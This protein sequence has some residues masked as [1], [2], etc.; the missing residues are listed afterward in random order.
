MFGWSAE[1]VV[2]R[3]LANVPADRQDEFRELRGRVL[4][5]NAFAEFETRRVRKDGRELDVLISTAPLH[6]RTGAI[7]GL[8]ALYQDV[9]A[10][11]LLE[12]DLRQA[13]KMEAVG[14]LAAVSRTTSTTCSP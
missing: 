5:G 8:V 12:A 13:Q 2:G 3:P 11:K 14:Q 1:E 10:K 6:D 4:R 7:V 9:T